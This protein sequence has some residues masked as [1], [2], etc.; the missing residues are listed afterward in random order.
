MH[1]LPV[2]DILYCKREQIAIFLPRRT[3]RMHEG[4]KALRL[5]IF[6]LFVKSLCPL[7]LSKLRQTKND[8]FMPFTV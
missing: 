5:R 6:V 8:I 7:C 3:Q 1:F 4:H 2:F